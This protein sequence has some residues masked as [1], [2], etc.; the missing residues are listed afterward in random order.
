LIDIKIDLVPFGIEEY[1]KCIAGVEIVNDGTGS[2]E[3][4]NYN[5]TF[6]DG[7]IVR[8]EKHRRAHD[9]YTLLFSALLKRE[10]KKM[11]KRADDYS[12]KDTVS[13]QG[14]PGLG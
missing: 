9:I 7:M 4:G 13:D 2:A 10:V 14:S 1:R 11:E 8:V 3:E 6:S 5:I 12:K